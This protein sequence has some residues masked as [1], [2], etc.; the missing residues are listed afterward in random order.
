LPPPP[1]VDPPRRVLARAVQVEG[2]A[3]RARRRPKRPC[4]QVDARSGLRHR[5]DLGQQ[6]LVSHG[7]AK[8]SL[9]LPA[10][11]PCIRGHC[12]TVTM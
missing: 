3:D 7:L 10:S 5:D 9:D 12:P 8:R 2:V 11:K 4:D 6:N 1:L